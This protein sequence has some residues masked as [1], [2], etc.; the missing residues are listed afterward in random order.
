MKKGLAFLLVIGLLIGALCVAAGAEEETSQED[1]PVWNDDNSP[2]SG[3]TPCGGGGGGG[4]GAP[5]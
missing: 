4:G 3:V 2:D 5:D 1:F